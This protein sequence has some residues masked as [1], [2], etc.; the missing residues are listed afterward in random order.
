[1]IL[2]ISYTFIAFSIMS[3]LV[4]FFFPQLDI[5]TTSFFYTGGEFYAKSYLPVLEHEFAFPLSPR[6]LPRI[7]GGRMTSAG[8][9]DQE[10]RAGKSFA[11]PR[12]AMPAHM[13]LVDTRAGPA[14]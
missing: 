2:N 6:R 5:F 14:V 10:R 8:S 11:M 7:P 13:H 3:A 9:I 1:M 4:F 12:P